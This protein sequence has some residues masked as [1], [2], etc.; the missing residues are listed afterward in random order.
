[1]NRKHARTNRLAGWLALTA[2]LLLTCMPVVSQVRATFVPHLHDH[3]LAHQGHEKHAVSGSIDPSDDECWKKCGYCDFLTHTPALAI[4]AY[5]PAFV[6]M[7][8]IAAVDYT[9]SGARFDSGIRVAQPRGPPAL[10]A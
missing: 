10:L 5:V 9:H 3:S 2:I 1:M 7:P 4:V 6:G 8:P